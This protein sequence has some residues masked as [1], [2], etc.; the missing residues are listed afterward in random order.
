MSKIYY[1]ILLIIILCICGCSSNNI[2]TQLTPDDFKPPFLLVIGDTTSYRMVDDDVYLSKD[3]TAQ[4]VE[5]EIILSKTPIYPS[6]K[7]AERKEADV[8]VS[9]CITKEGKARQARVI[10]STDNGFNR[11]AAEAAMQC[12]FK[13]GLIRNKPVACWALIPFNFRINDYLPP[14]HFKEEKVN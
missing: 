3:T 7:L 11:S 14:N 4:D 5:P 6:D 2:M 8:V 12:V 1:H 13:P 9:V 10:K